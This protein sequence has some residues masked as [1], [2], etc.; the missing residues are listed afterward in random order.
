M[1]NNMGII[2]QRQRKA[3][4]RYYLDSRNQE[5]Y[6][7]AL[8]SLFCPFRNEDSDIVNKD[9]IAEFDT[10]MAD[11]EKRQKFEIQLKTYQP[12]RQDFL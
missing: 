10:V 6:N 5:N 11:P 9:P 7:R 2:R 3:I 1:R 8:L 4:I 12:Y